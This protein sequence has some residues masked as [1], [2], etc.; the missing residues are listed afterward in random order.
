MRSNRTQRWL[1]VI[2]AAILCAT[3]GHAQDISVEAT[4]DRAYVELGQALELTVTVNGKEK[5]D[6]PPAPEVDGIQIRYL[7]PSTRVSIINGKYSRSVGFMYN[8]FPLKTGDFEIPPVTMNIDGQ[9]YVTSAIKV[10]VVERGQAASADEKKDGAVSDLKE[11]IF[12]VMGTTKKNFYLQERIPVSI[13]LFVNG[14]SVKN[15]TYPEFERAGFMAEEFQEPQRYQQAIEGMLFEVVDFK[16]AV[17]PTRTGELSLGPAQETCQIVFQRSSS[18]RRSPF[19]RFDSVFGEDFF[20]GFFGGTAIQPVTLESTDLKINVVPLPEDGQPKGFAG[21]VGTFNF[22]MTV[23]PQEV[24]VGDPVTV[25]MTVSGV[26]NLQAVEMPAFKDSSLWKVYEPQ[27]KTE[28]D[29]KILEQVVIP[30]GQ[31][32]TELP[33]TVFSYFDP[34]NGKYHTLKQGPFPLEVRAAAPGDELRVVGLKPGEFAMS[35]EPLGRD[36]RFIKNAP[37]ALRRVGQE[38]GQAG[39]LVGLIILVTSLWAGVLVYF[40]FT[41]R[42]KTDVRFAQRLKAPRYARKGLAQAGLY[43]DGGQ[44]KD[45]YDC[46]H[47]TLV[48][49]FA[50]KY[51][52]AQGSVDA[53]AV[54][55]L[56]V[57]SSAS[58]G[59]QEDVLRKV[60]DL[61]N[62]CEMVRYASIGS[63]KET[64]TLSL[65]KARE[66]IDFFERH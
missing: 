57:S 10:T 56:A 23:S 15:I 27:I 1:V 5:S 43:L 59:I 28:G 66:V 38:K 16:T 42:L 65:R 26:G 14:L 46:L 20:D 48:K 30:K 8:V 7:G 31:E 41:Q 22:V 61:F 49:Y 13:K 11:K 6:P 58:V 25:R 2:V 55:G 37:G 63:N 29:R 53:G 12:L 32:L 4:V 47:R 33:V 34:N 45:F 21:A 52:L 40:Q 24:A 39:K 50:H 35:E 60:D 18:R 3:T 54:R 36:I 19:N 9:D 62:E 64:M 51:H 44:E 17:Y